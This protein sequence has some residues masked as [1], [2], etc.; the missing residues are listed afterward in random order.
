MSAPFLEVK[1]WRT[2]QH[3]GKRRPPWIKLYTRLLDDPTFLALPEVVQAQLVKVWILAASMG[4]PLPNDPKLLAGKIGAKKLHLD[5]LLA[6]GFLIPCYQ[7]AS[8]S[9]AKCEQNA[10]PL[11]TENREQRKRTETT[12]PQPPAPDGA[13]LVR[14]AG[15]SALPPYDQTFEEAWAAYPKRDGNSKTGSWRAWLVR[16]GEGVDPLDMVAGAR[17]YAARCERERTEPRHIKHAQTFF[18]PDK[19]FASDWGP[20]AGPDPTPAEVVGKVLGVSADRIEALWAE[21]D[22]GLAIARRKGAA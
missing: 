12:T 6:S 5:A 18:G 2:H 15:R 14:K 8:N 4:H 10:R 22:Q 1:D 17:A 21:E 16:V 7:N 3:Y 9:L 11:S 13:R 19:H 20:V